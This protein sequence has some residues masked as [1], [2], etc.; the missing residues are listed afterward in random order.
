MKC[1]IKGCDWKTMSVEGFAALLHL[2]YELNAKKEGWNTR[3]ECKVAFM[4][5]PVENQRTMLKMAEFLLNDI[6]ICHIS[7]HKKE[8]EEIRRA[9][10]LSDEAWDD[11]LKIV[12]ATERLK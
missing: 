2:H 9:M 6:M 4:D 12:F 1:S 11:Y 10:R 3:E 7:G 5:L 8:R